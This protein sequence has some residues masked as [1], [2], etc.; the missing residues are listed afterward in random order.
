V[1]AK[2]VEAVKPIVAA[3]PAAP[4]KPVNSKG[5]NA[6]SE[7]EFYKFLA[8]SAPKQVPGSEKPVAKKPVA[9]P[10]PPK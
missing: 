10:T 2:P 3:K 5:I 6:P 4:Q 9:N 8:A 1:A 7:G